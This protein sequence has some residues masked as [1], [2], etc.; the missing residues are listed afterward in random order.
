MARISHSLEFLNSSEWQPCHSSEFE[1]SPFE[2]VKTYDSVR[3]ERRNFGQYGRKT[4]ASFWIFFQ[5]RKVTLNFSI[6]RIEVTENIVK[7]IEKRERKF[8][9]VHRTYKKFFDALLSFK[10]MKWRCLRRAPRRYHDDC[11]S[12][13]WIKCVKLSLDG[14]S[15]TL[16]WFSQ[17]SHKPTIRAPPIWTEASF[18][19]Q[20][21]SRETRVNVTYGETTV[22]LV[23]VSLLTLPKRLLSSMPPF[24]VCKTKRKESGNEPATSRTLVYHFHSA[25]SRSVALFI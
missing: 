22:W 6:F 13:R 11:P 15:F 24:V 14:R 3:V 8:L 4:R 20:Q 2:R 19:S 1:K 10:E 25:P 5:A 9:C 12:Q 17:G 7:T 18:S 16:F 23:A 21:S